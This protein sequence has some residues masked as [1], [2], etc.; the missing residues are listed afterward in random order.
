MVF[1]VRVRFRESWAADQPDL[2]KSLGS[3]SCES[4]EPTAESH[5]DEAERCQTM[6]GIILGSGGRSTDELFVKW[7]KFRHEVMSK[8]SE[9]AGSTPQR[10]RA[11]GQQVHYIT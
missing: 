10:A 3:S 2:S 7:M 9:V 11:P 1:V 5:V 8:G 6:D 4:A